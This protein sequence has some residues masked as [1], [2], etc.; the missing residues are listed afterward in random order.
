MNAWL[1]LRLKLA[2]YW[3]AHARTERDRREAEQTLRYVCAELKKR[4]VQD[5][6]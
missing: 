4:G 1:Q 6:R 5:E 3:L 2:R